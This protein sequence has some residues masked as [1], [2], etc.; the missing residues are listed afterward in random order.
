M[1][2][3]RP[4]LLIA[5]VLLLAL[6]YLFLGTSSLKASL[7]MLKR[8]RWLFM[9]ILI[10]Y[11]W[12]S[13]GERLWP[14]AGNWSPT[15][16]GLQFGLLRVLILMTIVAAVQLLILNTRREI[17]LPAIM[18]LIYPITT[19]ALRERFAVRTLLAIEY[20]PRVQTMAADIHAQQSDTTH[21]LG[22]L[23]NSSRQLYQ[24]VLQQAELAGNDSIE[25]SELTAPVWWQWLLPA[26]MIAVII[27]TM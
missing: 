4:G 27:L 1:S 5:G 26:T 22:R 3:A 9:A 23:A 24:N 19:R 25:I 15:L 12:W 10:I 16:V 14:A 6:L 18:Q 21:R 2:L 17:L 11:G 8:L 7:L 20:V 13:P